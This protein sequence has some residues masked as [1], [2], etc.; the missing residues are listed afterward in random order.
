MFMNEDALF[1]VGQKA[2]IEKD[3]QV[4][5]LGDPHEGLDYPGG[6]IQEGEFDLPESLKR[7]VREETGLE[8][9][10]GEPFATWSNIFPAHHKLGGKRV[11]LVGYRCKYISGDIKLSHEHDKF[12]WV[13][14]DTYNEVNDG[15]SYF[16][17][18][19]KYFN[20]EQL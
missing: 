2:F 19:N 8:I 12:N 13:T 11:F 16:D 5:V 18:L 17:I 6:K 3:G 4:L 1:Y 9:E 10:V 20:T 15:T 14:K 7:E